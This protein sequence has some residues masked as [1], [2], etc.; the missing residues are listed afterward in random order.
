MEILSDDP[1]NIDPRSSHE[2][3]DGNFYEA[4]HTDQFLRESSANVKN[5]ASV[6]FA[7]EIS[8]HSR[9]E[10][11]DSSEDFLHPDQYEA[12]IPRSTTTS[13]HESTPTRDFNSHGRESFIPRPPEHQI[14]RQV[15]PRI[16]SRSTVA[17]NQLYHRTTSDLIHQ[18]DPLRSDETRPSRLS[19][20]TPF[21]TANSPKKS[22]PLP[23]PITHSKPIVPLSPSNPPADNN[24]SGLVAYFFSDYGN[25]GEGEEEIV[26]IDQSNF[27][28]PTGAEIIADDDIRSTIMAPSQASLLILHSAH[29]PQQQQQHASALHLTKETN[30]ERVKIEEKEEIASRASDATKKHISTA[31]SILP[32]PSPP[33]KQ[34]L[35]TSIIED[36]QT[37]F[38]R[39]NNASNNDHYRQ[40]PTIPLNMNIVD[41]NIDDDERRSNNSRIFRRSASLSKT[42][43]IQSRAS[44]KNDEEIEKNDEETSSM[45]SRTSTP[46]QNIDNKGNRTPERI[47]SADQRIKSATKKFSRASS[48][49]SN[50]TRK[51]EE[52]TPINSPTK[53]LFRNIDRENSTS[54]MSAAH[55]PTSPSNERVRP[56]SQTSIFHD[57]HSASGEQFKPASRPAI[58]H[59]LQDASDD[60]WQPV[61]RASLY[62]EQEVNFDEQSQAASRMSTYREP[63]NVP[64]ERSES[65]SRTSAHREQPNIADEQSERSTRTSTYREPS[66]APIER[67]EPAS[68]TSGYRG[69]PHTPSE[70]PESASRNSAYRELPD[71]FDQQSQPPSRTSMSREASQTGFRRLIPRQPS[72][73]PSEEPFSNRQKSA[74]Q[75]SSSS[76]NQNVGQ[77]SDI[78]LDDPL[79]DSTDEL[80]KTPT[81]DNEP[82][83]FTVQS[84][85][86]LRNQS[87]TSPYDLNQRLPS[88]YSMSHPHDSRRSSATSSPIP[89]AL[90]SPDVDNNPHPSSR[91]VTPMRKTS[92][93]S[94]DLP[95]DPNTLLTTT[96]EPDP[97]DPTVIKSTIHFQ[98][99]SSQR[100][101]EKT[102]I[103]ERN[104]PSPLLNIVPVQKIPSRVSSVELPGELLPTEE[105]PAPHPLSASPRSPTDKIEFEL[106]KKSSPGT[107]ESD[108]L[109]PPTSPF[110]PEQKKP[111][112]RTP[113][114]LNN[115]QESARQSPS[116][117][118][119][120]RLEDLMGPTPSPFHTAAEHKQQEKTNRLP[121]I[122][123]PINPREKEI[124]H[125]PTHQASS[126][127]LG[128]IQSPLPSHSPLHREIS[129]H[130]SVEGDDTYRQ[131]LYTP[132]ISPQN[133]TAI[134]PDHIEHI[135]VPQ[136]N[137]ILEQHQVP[138]HTL[139]PPRIEPTFITE[140]QRHPSSDKSVSTPRSD[141]QE[142]DDDE[143]SLYQNH[144]PLN[145]A[146]V[147]P[148]KD[149]FPSSSSPPPRRTIVDEREIPTMT[150]SQLHSKLSLRVLPQES[151]R[152][153]FTDHQGA[154]P[155]TSSSPLPQMNVSIPRERQFIISI[156]YLERRC[157]SRGHRRAT[158]RRE[159]ETT[160]SKSIIFK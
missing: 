14:D 47:D 22:S 92:I 80:Q 45:S 78:P 76:R 100:P 123:P 99:L 109:L 97:D 159:S 52:R 129:N 62:R 12:N 148:T 149:H 25:E 64:D 105:Q 54:R 5:R 71:V 27:A 89:V 6:V 48:A 119:P 103:P 19:A 35:P 20:T 87:Q 107:P 118:Y 120:A 69:P 146:S 66:N 74:S 128:S 113:S 37:H 72:A 115:E 26:P 90:D 93:S 124:H 83:P 125:H 75:R 8:V 32:S 137:H 1:E 141:H 130:T 33:P 132:S 60:E 154:P 138:R 49:T 73:T 34:V 157:T 50:H 140:R 44:G 117:P 111:S 156:G 143:R 145:S 151:K 77:S 31:T 101:Q 43:R 91:T 28:V 81:K 42:S 17:S 152:K 9:T 158:F 131:Q 84:E 38:T 147:K 82:H 134:S 139:A 57:R 16:G 160:T 51:D 67:S 7:P 102:P 94:I 112:Q 70:R 39:N 88:G 127:K 53:T 24:V 116:L 46:L 98:M 110:N 153:K 121:S 95:P 86:F 133:E 13:V 36:M 126:P 2:V 59:R 79:V 85:H 18:N 63:M 150:P 108:V 65:V 30:N 114:S 122:S 23:T 11:H 104:Q 58:F 29:V 106:N 55:E 136:A 4:L 40:S 61:S 142:D 15:A 3:K 10:L 21:A 68:R 144:V 96:D 155:M 135:N 56:T 41:S